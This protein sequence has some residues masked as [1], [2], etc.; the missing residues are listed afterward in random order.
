MGEQCPSGE[1]RALTEKCGSAVVARTYDSHELHQILT[2]AP[3][4]SVPINLGRLHIDAVV[5]RIWLDGEEIALPPREFTILRYLA[6][7]TDR[8]VPRDELLNIAWGHNHRKTT[9]TLSVHIS[10]L[11]RRLGDTG[12]RPQW[13]IAIRKIGY[14]LYVPPHSNTRSP[15]VHPE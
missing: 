4:S 7:H 6:H 10:R 13:I 11:R 14:R 8:A 9:N 3:R 1:R 15:F 12:R 2:A 5:P